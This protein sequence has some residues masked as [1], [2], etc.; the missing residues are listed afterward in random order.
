VYDPGGVAGEQASEV[1]AA[2]RA[3]GAEA[4]VV[5]QPSDVAGAVERLLATTRDGLCAV[6]D[7]RLP[8]A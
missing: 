4:A 8:L 5:S 1:V 3:A 7:V 2:A 6:L